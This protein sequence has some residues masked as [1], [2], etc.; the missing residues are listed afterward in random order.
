MS[1]GNL[2]LFRDLLV[3]PLLVVQRKC[4]EL[5]KVIQVV[6]LAVEPYRASFV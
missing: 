5:L 6:A 4:N 3:M 2:F 1:L